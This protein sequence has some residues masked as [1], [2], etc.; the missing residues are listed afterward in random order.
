M[1]LPSEARED[2]AAKRQRQ[3]AYLA[4]LDAQVNQ[5][6]R[7]K[8]LEDVADGHFVRNLPSTPD[9]SLDDLL[10][11]PLPPVGQS[12]SPR[13]IGKGLKLLQQANNPNAGDR[14]RRY[15][16]AFESGVS[17]VLGGPTDYNDGGADAAFGHPAPSNQPRQRVGGG[18]AGKINLDLAGGNSS[19]MTKMVSEQLNKFD[20]GA[21]RTESTVHWLTEQL[22]RN[23]SDYAKHSAMMVNQH[24]KDSESL[25]ALRDRLRIAETEI[26]ENRAWRAEFE[27]KKNEGIE[28]SASAAIAELR[29]REE[30]SKARQLSEDNRTRRMAEALSEVASKIETVKQNQNRLEDDMS[31]RLGVVENSV[32]AQTD[33][34]VNLVDR[35]GESAANQNMASESNNAGIVDLQN[36]LKQLMNKLASEEEQRRLLQ[37]NFAEMQNETRR[38]IGKEAEKL[39]GEIS[40][41]AAARREGAGD[42]EE[43][44]KFL[45]SMVEEREKANMEMV[46][47]RIMRL[48]KVQE[49]EAGW[50]RKMDEERDKEK[51]R[52]FAEIISTAKTEAATMKARHEANIAQTMEQLRDLS[53]EVAR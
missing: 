11:A 13:G 40:K 31:S 9:D 26:L 2:R 32:S 29:A 44:N 51:Q 6:Q 20:A 39:H 53:Q 18:G 38:L 22:K 17:Q 36:S 25:A 15:G 24:Q 23:R 49:R 52:F 46:E 7:K 14:G 10:L 27:R 41:E 42:I 35:Q 50:R 48:E 43:K 19:L 3:R 1:N 8:A 4:S 16:K 45:S 30:D 47:E 12:H 5:Q 34:I 37:N 21:R 33:K 28:T